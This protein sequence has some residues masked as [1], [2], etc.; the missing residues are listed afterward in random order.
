MGPGLAEKS[1][2]M[3]SLREPLP[4]WRRMW[5]QR[6]F[7]MRLWLAAGLVAA[8]AAAPVVAHADQDAVQAFSD[9]HI[10]PESPAHDVVCFFCSVH[11]DGTVTGDIVALFGSIDISGTASH[12]VVSLFGGVDVDDNASIARDLV[13][14]FGSLRLGQNATVG[15]DAVALFSSIQASASATVKGQRVSIPAIFFWGPITIPVLLIFLIIYLVRERHRR[16]IPPVYP[17][18][19]Q[20]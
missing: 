6:F 7:A 20:G 18:P 13:S 2:L 12:D 9:I 17:P 8:L 4:I 14:I 16:W 10:T 19:R 1:G 11:D 5:K 15:R 3:E